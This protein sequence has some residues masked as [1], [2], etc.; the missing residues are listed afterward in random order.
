M[1]PNTDR[2]LRPIPTGK[3]TYTVCNT[4]STFCTSSSP[5]PRD[6]A[7]SYLLNQ[8]HGF[9]FSLQ[10]ARLVP[11]PAVLRTPARPDAA[12]VSLVPRPPHQLNTSNK[13]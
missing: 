9:S 7:G 6:E 13:R 10:P 1:T 2:E 5:P 3:P 12:W 4:R 8:L 11:R